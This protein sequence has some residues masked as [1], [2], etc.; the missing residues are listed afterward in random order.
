MPSRSW[1]LAASLR[2]TIRSIR[3][4]SRCRKLPRQSKRPPHSNDMFSRTRIRRRPSLGPSAKERAAQFG[5]SAE[6]LE[7]NELVL[8]GGFGSLEICKRAGI[9]VGYGSDLIGELQSEQSREF[10]LRREVA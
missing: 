6:K 1:S 7:K 9:K 10:M 3:V 8:K 2:R 4:S 5:M